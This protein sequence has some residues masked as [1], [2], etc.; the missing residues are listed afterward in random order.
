MPGLGSVTVLGWSVLMTLIG[1]LL[2][3]SSVIVSSRTTALRQPPLKPG[4]FQPA[5]SRR[6][7]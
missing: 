6:A 1:G 4:W 7:S 3:G 5:R 2:S